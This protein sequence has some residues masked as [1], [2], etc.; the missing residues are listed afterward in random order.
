MLLAARKV[1]L[2]QLYHS[3]KTKVKQWSRWLSLTQKRSRYAI[4]IKFGLLWGTVSFDNRVVVESFFYLIVICPAENAELNLNLIYIQIEIETNTLNDNFV[5][6]VSTLKPL[7]TFG[8]I[9][10][11]WF[12]LQSNYVI[13]NL[14]FPSNQICVWKLSDLII[15]TLF[16][17]GNKVWCA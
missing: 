11:Y 5:D 15:K 2:I 14:G 7:L 3:N 6:F 16:F 9:C 10:W 12:F 4:L 13:V 1:Y 8:C 17:Y